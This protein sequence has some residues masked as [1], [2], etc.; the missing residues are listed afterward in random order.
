MTKLAVLGG[1][2]GLSTLLRGLKKLLYLFVM[3]GVVQ[4]DLEKNLIL[5]QLGT[6]ERF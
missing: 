1:G 4:E 3:M 2:T 6:L 5:L